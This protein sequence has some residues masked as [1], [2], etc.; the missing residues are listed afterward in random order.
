MSPGGYM[1]SVFQ[2]VPCKGGIKP[3]GHLKYKIFTAASNP[4][5]LISCLLYTL[6]L[7]IMS[8]CVSRTPILTANVTENTRVFV[9][10]TECV[11]STH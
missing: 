3:F 1:K 5:K 4:V 10:Y 6:E 8:V 9:G 2:S 11:S 7:F